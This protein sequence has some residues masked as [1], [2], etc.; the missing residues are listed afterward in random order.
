MDAENLAA[1]AL[2][3][4]VASAAAL[5]LV[6]RRDGRLALAVGAV[7]RGGAIA[8]MHYL[9]MAALRLPA[10]VTYDRALVAASVAGERAAELAVRRAVGASR[11][12]LI[13]AALAAGR[14]AGERLARTPL[15]PRQRAAVAAV[16]GGDR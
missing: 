3:A 12:T 1:A 6:V 4:V 14:R 15:T 7:L 11:R 2:V 13:A 16:M 5:G 8:G 9:G 10:A